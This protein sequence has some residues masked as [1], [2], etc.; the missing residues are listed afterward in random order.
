[1][2]DATVSLC[3]DCIQS[4]PLTRCASVD[5]HDDSGSVLSTAW[6]A[7]GAERGDG[8]V[9]TAIT[10]LTLLTWM[11]AHFNCKCREGWNYRM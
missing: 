3:V 6:K 5:Q 8:V 2:V 10:L 1:V 9:C 11:F 7:P 4:A